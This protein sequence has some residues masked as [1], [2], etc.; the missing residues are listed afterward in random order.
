MD[1]RERNNATPNSKLNLSK[2][3]REEI[4]QGRQLS[5]CIHAINDNEVVM[6]I[7]I[8]FEPSISYS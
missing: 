4:S 7:V 5:F 3:Q 2:P 8:L 6:Q 1:L